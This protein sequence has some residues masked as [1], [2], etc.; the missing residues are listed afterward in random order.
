MYVLLEF[1]Y[2]RHF[3]NLEYKDIDSEV[4]VLKNKKLGNE[5]SGVSI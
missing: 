4:I 3:V 2:R 5:A 1:D